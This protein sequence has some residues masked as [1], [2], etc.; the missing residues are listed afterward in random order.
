MHKLYNHIGPD[1]T[2]II[3]QLDVLYKSEKC[4]IISLQVNILHVRKV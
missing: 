3:Y 1:Y 4:K 2:H